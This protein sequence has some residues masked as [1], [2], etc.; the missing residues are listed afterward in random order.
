MVVRADDPVA[1]PADACREGTRD[2][3]RRDT[4][5]APDGRTLAFV[6]DDGPSPAGGENLSSL[7]IADCVTGQIRRLLASRANDDPKLDLAH[8]ETPRFSLD[9]A[10]VYFEADAWATSS[11]VHQISVATGQEHF[12]IDGGVVG[13]IRNGPYRGYLLVGRHRYHPPPMMGSFDPV[14]VVG[15]DASQSFMVPG[16]DKDNGETSVQA[17]LGSH[18]WTAD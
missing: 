15:P 17:W 13:I 12:V 11:A 10:Y 8:V 16:S 7:W 18:G 3:K 5:L 2:G 4:A 6:H 9:G 1:P 14:Y